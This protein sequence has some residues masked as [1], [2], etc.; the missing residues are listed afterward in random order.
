VVK[1][2]TH[3]QVDCSRLSHGGAILKTKPLIL[4]VCDCESQAL[5]LGVK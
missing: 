2:V 5:L 1:A 3:M 4:L